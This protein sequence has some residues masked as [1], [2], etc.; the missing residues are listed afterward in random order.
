MKI[1]DIEQRLESVSL[2]TASADYLSSGQTALR[3]N[4]N[5]ATWWIPGLPFAEG[6]PS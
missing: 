4:A 5:F 3:T 6:G 2:V 1:E